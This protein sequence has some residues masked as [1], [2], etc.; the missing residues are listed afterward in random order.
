M[1]ELKQN[2]GPVALVL[3]GGG[4]RGGDEIG[5]VS[6]LLPALK[7]DEQPQ[8]IIGTSVGA[9][10]AA[11]LAAHAHESPQQIAA[12]GTELWGAIGYG[13]VLKPLVSFSEG[14]RLGSYLREVWGSRRAHTY[15]LL[16]PTPL[17]ATLSKLIAFDQIH[18]NVGAGH[19]ATAAV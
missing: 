8:I 7:E 2:S 5:V 16:D 10:N 19:L 14:M 4:A 1:P 13:S 12:G 3:A 6:A 9:I 11:Y 17:T 15:S 18:T